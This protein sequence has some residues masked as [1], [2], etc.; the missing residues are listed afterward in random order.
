MYFELG[1]NFISH[2]PLIQA[3]IHLVTSSIDLGFTPPYTL[4]TSTPFDLI[5]CFGLISP[6]GSRSGSPPLLSWAKT[7]SSEDCLD[8]RDNHPFGSRGYLGSTSLVAHPSTIHL[9]SPPH[10]GNYK[11]GDNNTFSTY[12]ILI[13]WIDSSRWCT[14]LGWSTYTFH[15]YISH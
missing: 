4:R 8:W 10:K 3:L 7:T 11:F 14:P 6:V 1:S 9:G 5:W 12:S 2:K 15:Y 13:L